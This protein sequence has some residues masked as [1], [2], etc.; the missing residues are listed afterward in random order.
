MLNSPPSVVTSPQSRLGDS[1]SRSRLLSPATATSFLSS[2]PPLEVKVP[3]TAVN[4]KSRD[5]YRHR[6]FEHPFVKNSQP[7]LLS[8]PT[9]SPVVAHVLQSTAAAMKR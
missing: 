8:S 5:M 6:R 1:P 9:L 4:A 2:E 3:V 7:H